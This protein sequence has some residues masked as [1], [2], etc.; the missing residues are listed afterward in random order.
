M[1]YKN[2]R[3][4]ISHMSITAHF[5]VCQLFSHNFQIIFGRKNQRLLNHGGHDRFIYL[6]NCCPTG[7][8]SSSSAQHGFVIEFGWVLRMG[9]VPWPLFLD[10]FTHSPETCRDVSE[11]ILALPQRRMLPRFHLWSTNS[12]NCTEISSEMLQ[13]NVDK[14]QIYRGKTNISQ[15]LLTLHSLP[16]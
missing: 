2:K 9:N 16:W 4:I 12:V 15:V 5:A 10:K 14:Q 1:Y 8:S 13:D 6:I 11:Q 3:I 7:Y